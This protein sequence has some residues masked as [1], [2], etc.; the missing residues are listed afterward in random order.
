M[1]LQAAPDGHRA[2][3][4]MTTRETLATGPAA[5]HAF[6]ADYQVA[7]NRQPNW[8]DKRREEQAFADRDPDVLIVGGGH[9]GMACAAS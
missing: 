9:A 3:S 4:L 1:R 2:L 7:D 8:L 6:G 5:G